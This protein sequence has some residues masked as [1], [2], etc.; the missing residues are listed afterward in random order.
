[1]SVVETE[2]LLA[3]R[4]GDPHHEAALR[5]ME[6]DT[7]LS[8]CGSAFLE[9]A[10]LM[11]SQSR[12]DEEIY[13]ALLLLRVELEEKGIPEIPVTLHQIIRAHQIL[14]EHRHNVTFF[15][16][17]I[18]SNAEESDDRTIVS[19]DDVFEVTK[20]LKRTPLK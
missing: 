1:M 17:L 16:A 3:L 7:S 13:R 14:S 6:E 20:T 4:E 12:S 8:V 15:D 10:W 11:R 5:L 18:L 9:L 19:N 2:F